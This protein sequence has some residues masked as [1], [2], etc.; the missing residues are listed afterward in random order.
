MEGGTDPLRHDGFGPEVVAEPVES[1]ARRVPQL[2]AEEAV[3]LDTKHVQVDVATC[4]EREEGVC[5]C[6]HVS[7]GSVRELV[8]ALSWAVCVC[9]SDECADLL[10]VGV[11]YVR[12]CVIFVSVTVPGLTLCGVCVCVWVGAVCVSVYVRLR[13]L[14]LT[15]GAVCY[16]ARACACSDS[17]WAVC[18][19]VCVGSPGAVW[20]SVSDV[21][22]DLPL[23]CAR[24]HPGRCVCV[25]VCVGL[26]WA[27]CVCVWAQP[28]Q[29][30]CVCVCVCAHPGRCVCVCVCVSVLTH[31]GQCRRTERT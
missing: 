8:C 20:G 12:V 27:V 19:C 28:G 5:V 9:L 21:C 1:E 4:G 15:L 29:C 6:T 7:L 22:A 10:L 2:V 13:T 23:V 25:C 30:V 3:T 17:P 14:N 16:R 18:V 24:T 26:A 11:V 31:P